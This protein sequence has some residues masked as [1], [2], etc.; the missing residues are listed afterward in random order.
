MTDEKVNTKYGLLDAYLIEARSIGGLSGSPV[1]VNLG[2]VRSI[3]GKLVKSPASY[4]PHYFLGLIHGHWDEAVNSTPSDTEDIQ[5]VKSVNM[6]IA[7]VTP[8][9]KILDLL[10][11]A[12]VKDLRDKSFEQYIK[13]NSK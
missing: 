1:F 5:S 8:G 10:N 3:N 4:G 12:R 7:I 11:D 9:E 2:L 6:G 13:K